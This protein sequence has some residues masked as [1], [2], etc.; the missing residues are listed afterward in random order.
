[1]NIA[2]L[3]ICYF[4]KKR[5]DLQITATNIQDILMVGLVDGDPL[6]DLLN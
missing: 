1:M 6:D 2:E 5:F 4:L 3:Q